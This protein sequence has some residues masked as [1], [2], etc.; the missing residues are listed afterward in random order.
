MSRLE[1]FPTEFCQLLR[2]QL[3]SPPFPPLFIAY[4]LRTIVWYSTLLPSSQP[5][6][7]SAPHSNPHPVSSSPVPHISCDSN[8]P[9]QSQNNTTHYNLPLLSPLTPSSPDTNSPSQSRNYATHFVPSLPFSQIHPSTHHHSLPQ[10][11]PTPSPPIPAFVPLHSQL[12]INFLDATEIISLIFYHRLEGPQRPPRHILPSS[13][14]HTEPR[15]R[16]YHSQVGLETSYSH[17]TQAEPRTPTQSRQVPDYKSLSIL[18][19]SC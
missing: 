15:T 8:S 14:I 16:S 6:M 9:F 10:L 17:L 18:S 3:P 7:N 5:C 12:T 4:F 1:F 19:S 11:A 2:F 13:L